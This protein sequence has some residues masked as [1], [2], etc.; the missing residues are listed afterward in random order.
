MLSND[1]SGGTSFSEPE[2]DG[3]PELGIVHDLQVG[4]ILPQDILD[5]ILEI[6][7]EFRKTVVQADPDQLDAWKS[8]TWPVLPILT[9]SRL[10]YHTAIPLLYRDVHLRDRS[11]VER[12]LCDPAISSYAH[13]KYLSLPASKTWATTRIRDRMVQAVLSTTAADQEIRDRFASSLE[14]RDE[15]VAQWAR[16]KRPKISVVRLWIG[17]IKMISDA[18]VLED[19]HYM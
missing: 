9:S 12:F 6:Y 11:E 8:P 17:R 18:K 16:T 3:M 14:A 13:V 19:L 2:P 4:A 1:I 15:I 10:L 5:L 7:F